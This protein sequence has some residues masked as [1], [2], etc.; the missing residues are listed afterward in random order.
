M[1]R[2]SASLAW[3][4]SALLL[5]DGGSASLACA[6]RSRRNDQVEKLRPAINVSA[7]ALAAA[8][9]SLFLRNAFWSRYTVLGGRATT[10]SLFKCR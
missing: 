1:L 9:S 7:T 2:C 8:K 5:F 3:A 6:L 10:G 4:V